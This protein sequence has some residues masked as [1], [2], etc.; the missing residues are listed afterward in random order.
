MQSWLPRKEEIL[1]FKRRKRLFAQHNYYLRHFS[2][3]CSPFPAFHW[4]LRKKPWKIVAKEKR[5]SIK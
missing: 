5:E 1:N 4:D 2:L 3:T